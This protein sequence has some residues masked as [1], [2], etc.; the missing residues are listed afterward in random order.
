MTLPNFLVLGPGRSGT[1]SLYYWLREHPQIYMNPVIVEAATNEAC[2]YASNI[3]RAV[4]TQEDY[5]RL[6]DGVTTEKAIGEVCPA[7]FSSPV[8][9]EAILAALPVVKLIATL[10]NP[11]DRAYSFWSLLGTPGVSAEDG[12][13]QGFHGY[14]NGFYS[15]DLR[16][17]FERFPRE[18]IRIILFD[19]LVSRPDDV[20]RGIFEFLDVDPAVKV[21]THITHNAS[22]TIR[23]PRV[24]R[25]LDLGLKLA[26]P[27]VPRRFKGKRAA[28]L[29]ERP[30]MRKPAPI[31]PEL[32]SRLLDEYQDD[33]LETSR[34][35]GRDL[36]H[37]LR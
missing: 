36:S 8:A 37:W 28:R 27:L 21:S 31:S 5:E 24:K 23:Y 7:Y 15:V 14:D 10:R 30:L 19:D 2:Y 34:L 4:T 18:N 3:Q 29:L 1:T 32:R 25:A 16:Q 35:I 9:R 33:I 26:Y 6:F 11:A 17:W 22:G 12:I 13:R 20:M